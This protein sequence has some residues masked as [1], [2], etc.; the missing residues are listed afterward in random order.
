MVER[1]AG[2]GAPVAAAAVAVTCW[3]LVVLS[4]VTFLVADP[5]IDSN[6]LF[7]LVDV[8]GSAVYGTVAGVVLARRVHPVPI[9]LGAAAIGIGLAALGYAYSQWAAVRPDL[10][11]VDVLSPL[12]NTAWIP[13]TLALF[14]VIPWLV[15]D[16]RLDD[17]ARV[18][19]VAG[20]L[21]TAWFFLARTFTDVSEV[22]LLAPVVAVG[23][24]A[25]ADVARR[26]RSGPVDERVGL[27]WLALGTAL[28]ALSFVPLML[29]A[30]VP[31][32]WMIT[33]VAHL[34]VQPFF[35]GAIFVSILRQRMWGLD[36]AVSRAVLA[37]SLTALLIGLYVVVATVLAGL[38]PD[39]GSTGAQF[40]AAAVVA[41]AVQPSE[42]GCSTGCTGWSTARG[43]NQGTRCGNSV[44]TSG[45]PS[46]RPN[47]SKA[48]RG[49]R[50]G[51]AARIGDRASRRRRRVGVL[52]EGHR[53][54]RNRGP[55]ASR[56]PRRKP[57]GDR[58]T[59]RVARPPL[60]EIPVRVGLCGDG[61]S[62]RRPVRRGPGDRTT[63]TGLGAGRG[64]PGDPT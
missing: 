58:T 38:L 33:P 37:G 36:L 13:G 4:L 50:S 31:G 14:L 34:V 8:V 25:A 42:C 64:T 23:F 53:S 16:H 47:C 27:G 19:L 41:V 57:R 45:A 24:V 60:A 1:I 56:R 48:G 17:A 44:G 62:R 54:G 21:V 46:P 52:G 28:M 11:W 59:R 35:L 5:G 30:T 63:S 3:T 9:I 40:V 6:Q 43:A 22:P 15:R 29:P 2:V 61:W 20:T 49:G 39:G 32:L 10:P 18:G 51:T 26:W 12:Q 55:G 7:F